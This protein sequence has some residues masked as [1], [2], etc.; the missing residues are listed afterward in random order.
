MVMIKRYIH[1]N[2]P[3][4]MLSVDYIHHEI[5]TVAISNFKIY[6][7]WKLIVSTYR[8]RCTNSTHA[9]KAHMAIFK[10]DLTRNECIHIIHEFA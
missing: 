8:E 1:F 5:R 3:H 9:H 4:F 2:W 7:Y 6:P 10:S